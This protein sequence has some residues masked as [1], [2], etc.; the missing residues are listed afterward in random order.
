MQIGI[1][2]KN[3]SQIILFKRNVLHKWCWNV[4]QH[5][6]YP[7]MSLMLKDTG[8]MSSGIAQNWLP[9]TSKIK[10]V[11]TMNGRKI[12]EFC[13]TIFKTKYYV[14]LGRNE[15]DLSKAK[16]KCEIRIVFTRLSKLEE[17]NFSK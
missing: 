6:I 5:L 15:V 12:C 13:K 17:H 16:K 1:Y 7:A 11:I 8:H 10:R 3:I 14:H 2:E 4:S 9:K